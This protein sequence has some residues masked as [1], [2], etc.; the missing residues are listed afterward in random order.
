MSDVKCSIFFYL[1]TVC[2][3]VLEFGDDHSTHEPHD[4]RVH[5]F[6]CL[7]KCRLLELQIRNSED[8]VANIACKMIDMFTTY[9]VIFHSIFNWKFPFC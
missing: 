1:F 8:E 6:D 4:S 3:L 2:F 5:D 9:S 7:Q